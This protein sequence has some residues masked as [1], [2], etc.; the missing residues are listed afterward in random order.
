LQTLSLLANALDELGREEVRDVLRLANR[1]DPGDFHIN[2][3]L[4]WALSHGHKGN[5]DEAIRFY[6]AAVALRPRNAPARTFLAIALYDRGRPE[7]ALA[8]YRMAIEIDRRFWVGYEALGIFQ[9]N[10]GNYDDAVITFTKAIEIAPEFWKGWY[11]R[12]RAYER[13]HQW[14][15]AVSDLSKALERKQG[16]QPVQ[17]LRGM[18]YAA[19]GNWR[20]AQADLAPFVLVHGDDDACVPVAC[21]FLLVR[22][23]AAYRKLCGRVASRAGQMTDMR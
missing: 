4:G 12:G 15:E 10:T 2:V 23:M 17:R 1:R 18:C 19:L 16:E 20:E 6:T 21:L 7:D 9:Y 8:E 11:W 14:R 5:L 13:C 22:D 3:Q